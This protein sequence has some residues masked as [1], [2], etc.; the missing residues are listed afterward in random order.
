MATRAIHLS[1]RKKRTCERCLEVKYF[2]RTISEAA[3]RI[4]LRNMVAA[5]TERDIEHTCIHIGG[6]L[7]PE[8][9]DMIRW[10]YWLEL[11]RREGEARDEGRKGDGL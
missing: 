4:D 1:E 2:P 6:T 3:F 8:G 11:G 5:V 7:E 9:N 10:S